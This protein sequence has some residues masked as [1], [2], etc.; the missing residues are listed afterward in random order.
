MLRRAKPFGEDFK[1]L[2]VNF[3]TKLLMHFGVRS[4]AVD[5]GWR[6]QSVLRPKR[7][8]STPELVRL[9]KA[10]VLSFIESGLAGYFHAAASIL[11]NID[12]VQVRFLKAVCLSDTEAL[13]NF[14]LAPLPL[15]RDFAILGLLHRVTLGIAPKQL[16]D[17]LP[18]RQRAFIG[19]FVCSRVRGATAFHDQQLLDRV[20]VHSSDEM[21]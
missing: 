19:D 13:L 20:S 11:E 4:I 16:V 9:Y 12:R 17:L 6:L 18:R 15:R 8:F 1:L 10:L 2:G 7:F 14:R 3:D 21:K 5:A